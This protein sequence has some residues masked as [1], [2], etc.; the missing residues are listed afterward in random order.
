MRRYFRPRSLHPGAWWAWALGAAV[1]ASRTTNPLVL[2]LLVACLGLVVA[3]RRPDAP[4]ALSFRLYLWLGVFIVVL[5]TAFRVFFGGDGA[6]VLVRLPAIPLPDFGAQAH[7]LGPVSAEALL[8]GVYGGLQLA[9][10]VVCVGAANSLANPRRLLAALPSALY[11]L[12][13]VVVIALSVFP[14]LAES[15][16]RVN[17][18]RMLRGHAAGRARHPGRTRRDD[19]LASGESSRP[20]A[21]PHGSERAHSRHVLRE[22][23]LPVFADALDRS[24]E[25]AGAMDSRGYGRRV[26]ALGPSATA[27]R[28]G[29]APARPR[30]AA[31]QRATS[32]VL[33]VAVLAL[34]VGA[35]AAL[36]P[37]T[38]PAALGLPM[39]VGGLLAAGVG[40]W[41]AGRWTRR[42]RYRPDRWGAAETVTVCCGLVPAV[43]LAILGA[44]G[45]E[46]LFPSTAP[47]AWPTLTGLVLVAVLASALPAVLTPKKAP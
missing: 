7:L 45:D 43:I 44:Q 29:R 30:Q 34:C 24:L 10:M 18:A 5:R 9:A 8:G 25:L 38:M 23:F 21:R 32:A 41:L 36:D 17:R 40:L 1:A 12:G 33:V 16:Q 39:L 28:D 37:S 13:S 22:V 47:P 46:V 35:Y 20:Q 14:Q 26:P 31:S 15:V 6:T 2:V 3:A 4:W 11:E 19:E 42:S 27:N